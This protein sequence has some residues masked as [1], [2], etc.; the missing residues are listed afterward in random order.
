MVLRPSMR[1]KARTLSSSLRTSEAATTGS[2]DPTAMAPPSSISRRHRNRKFGAPSFR[3]ATVE[4]QSPR[5]KL[6]SMMR[7]FS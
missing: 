7:S 5:T 6:S 4:T 2:F 3:L 1:S